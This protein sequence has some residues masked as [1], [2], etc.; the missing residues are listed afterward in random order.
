M[1]WAVG[2]DTSGHRDVGYGDVNTGVHHDHVN[3]SWSSW[4]GIGRLVRWRS[5]TVYIVVCRTCGAWSMNED[6]WT[7]PLCTAAAVSSDPV[8]EEGGQ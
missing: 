7:E 1:S 5:K 8:Q 3:L 2:F 4:R 6:E